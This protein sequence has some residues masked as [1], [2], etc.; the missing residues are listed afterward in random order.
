MDILNY[1]YDK[2][3]KY[4]KTFKRK[5]DIDT[6]I[7]IFGPKNSGKTS[8][9]INFISSTSCSCLFLDMN[10]MRLESIH[11]NQ[12]EEFILKN[13]I[14]V[15]L[16]DNITKSTIIPNVDNIILTTNEPIEIKNI[17]PL[18]L[19]NLDFEEF[20]LFN[21]SNI[22]ITHL[23][24][25][26]I[27]DGNMANIIHSP[28]KE[29]EVQNSFN[30][31]YSSI[32]LK[33][34]RQYVKN[35]SA[36]IS[37][38]QIFNQL[39]L[40]IKISKDFFYSFTQRLIK[41]NTIFLLEKYNHPKSN[42]KVYLYDFTLINSFY[43][44]AFSK[45][46]ENAIFLELYTKDFDLYYSDKFNFFIPLINHAI[47]AH[48]FL[49]DDSFIDKSDLVFSEALNMGISKVTFVTI[50]YEDKLSIEGIVFEAIPFWLW[51]T[52]LE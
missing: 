26:F 51:A 52:S 32:E 20:I 2:K 15:L 41:S 3:F 33:I 49:D 5:I 43:H 40:I 4:L 44:I 35:T 18:P 27:K 48:V 21:N 9:L 14:D 24:N 11:T 28:L 36:N 6:N 38:F 1:Y 10:D 8:L 16:L 37:L 17:K 42:K 34:L 50:G 13:N 31:I 22:N 7:L 12:I 46:F 39:K 45:N 30:T 25:I 29:L 23:F 19:F 47:I